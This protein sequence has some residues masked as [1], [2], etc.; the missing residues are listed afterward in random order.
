MTLLQPASLLK[1]GGAC[2]C[3]GDGAGVAGSC[4]GPAGQP[5]GAMR[6]R[7]AREGASDMPPPQALET[8]PAT[9]AAP[10]GSVLPQ[11]AL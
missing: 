4:S 1:V 5:V 2:R 10:R 8:S 11:L 7:W 9:P 3:E 6:G